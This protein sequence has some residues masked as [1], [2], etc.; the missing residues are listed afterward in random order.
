RLILQQAERGAAIFDVRQAQ[1]VAYARHG[2][3]AQAAALEAVLGDAFGDL[4]DHDHE[5]GQAEE[6]QAAEWDADFLARGF[7]GGNDVGD[8]LS[9]G[10]GSRRTATTT[11]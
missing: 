3:G 6:Q 7:D 1:I 5:R 9:H 4:V 2:D 8:G 11:G 10:R